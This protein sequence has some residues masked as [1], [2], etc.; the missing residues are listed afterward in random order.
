VKKREASTINKSNPISIAP[1][2]VASFLTSA[3]SDPLAAW[4]AANGLNSNAIG[5]NSLASIYEEGGFVPE[6]AN[7]KS[8]LSPLERFKRAVRMVIVINRLSDGHLKGHKY[9]IDGQRIP[10]A[11]SRKAMSEVGLEYSY[12]ADGLQSV[13]SKRFQPMQLKEGCTST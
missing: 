11:V 5:F 3:M 2:L 10:D 7:G 9:D 13:K 1:S 4:L 6:V 8:T 12:S